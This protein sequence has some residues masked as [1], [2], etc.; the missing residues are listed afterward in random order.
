MLTNL[1]EAGNLSA[2]TCP[3]P[4]PNVTM[5]PGCVARHGELPEKVGKC[6]FEENNG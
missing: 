3:M 1:Y 5:P 2:A 6:Y 4:G